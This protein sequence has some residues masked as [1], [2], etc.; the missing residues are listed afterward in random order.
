LAA[1]LALGVLAFSGS[2]A[3]ANG[4]GA[5][6]G[7]ISFGIGANL[8]WD[9]GGGGYGGPCYGGGYCAPQMYDAYGYGGYSG[10][11]GGGW[12]PAGYGAGNA[13]P[14]YYGAPNAAPANGHGK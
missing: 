9:F 3:E 6:R 5:S 13:Y 7:S 12:P 11:Y 2:K 14:G 10:Y 8:S 4:F 1:A